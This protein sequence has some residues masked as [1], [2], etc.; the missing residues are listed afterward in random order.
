MDKAAYI[1]VTG[2]V[3]GVGFRWFVERGAKK[4]GLYGYVKNVPNGDVEIDV[5]GDENL[6]KEMIRMIKVGNSH[7]RVTGVDVTWKEYKNKHSSFFIRF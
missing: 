4:I 5:E 7:S 2:T 3:Q 1:T 6:I